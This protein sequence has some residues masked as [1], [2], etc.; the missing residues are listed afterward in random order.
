MVSE[1]LRAKVIKHIYDILSYIPAV[2]CTFHIRLN[3]KIKVQQFSAS[4]SQK[5][6]TR[7]SQIVSLEYSLGGM[8]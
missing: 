5:V 2:F 1:K 6:E 7:K 3:K 4:F 8:A